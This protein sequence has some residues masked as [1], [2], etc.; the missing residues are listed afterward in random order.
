MPLLLHHNTD[1]QGKPTSVLYL[2]PNCLNPEQ[3]KAQKDR[4]TLWHQFCFA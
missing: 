3:L 1:S 2:D 4:F